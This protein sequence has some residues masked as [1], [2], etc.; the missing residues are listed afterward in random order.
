VTDRDED[1]PPQSLARI[2][3]D[4]GGEELGGEGTRKK[5]ETMGLG[6]EIFLTGEIIDAPMKDGTRQET[7][8]VQNDWVID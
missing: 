8:K 3:A 7:C 4:G 2:R 6:A 5:T 1:A